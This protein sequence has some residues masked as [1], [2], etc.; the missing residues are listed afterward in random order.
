MAELHDLTAEAQC[1]ALRN[2]DIS[3]SELVA[4][5][6][7]RIEQHGDK[8]GAFVNVFAEHAMSE[9]RLADGRSSPALL[10]GLPVPLKDLHPSAGLPT[11]L[12]S[13]AVAGWVPEQDGTVVGRLR[14]AGIIV[15]GKTHAPE[16]GP[17]CYTESRLASPAISPYGC[18]LSASGS[19]GGAAAAVAA[20]LAPLAHASD[21]LGSTRTPAANCGLVGVKPSRGRIPS[22]AP[23][24]FQ[25]GIE[26][27]VART[28]GD[29]ALFLDAIGSIGPGEIWRQP[30]WTSDANRA[31]AR[32]PPGRLR[33]GLL[34]DPGTDQ[35][36]AHAACL[37]A[38]ADAC[39][40][41]QTL[42]HEIVPMALPPALRL[43][44]IL[45]PILDVLSVGLSLQVQ[46]MVP[47]NK[48][49]LLM[50]YT[51]WHISEAKGTTGFR[52]ARAM[53]SLSSAAA[54]WLKWQSAVDILLT[55]TSAS[56]A[57]ASG[58]LRLDDGWK[59]TEAMLRWSAFT[60]W[61]NLCG[62][63]AV[64]LPVAETP[65]GVPVGI[66]LMGKP[67]DDALLLGL[68]GSLEEVFNWQ[69]RHPPQW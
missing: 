47:E 30:E 45:E 24:W 16:F 22:V 58:A 3:S 12:G 9:A 25:I 32:R 35:A 1:A 26:G 8:L 14:Q 56:P 53:S 51:R 19:S 38:C 27:P 4:H 69:L 65:E 46:A 55:P 54:G 7:K 20:G 67:G 13:A 34:T 60:P 39:S 41:L 68:S 57:L 31:A 49:H 11:S 43:W 52:Y 5:Y 36:T 29:A 37:S 62:S 21:G 40:A 33:I 63:P 44:S 15:M 59:S 6:L 61:A 23:G 64:S 50:P 2:R 42:G 28:V 48:R 17:C 66:Q 10:H 18:D